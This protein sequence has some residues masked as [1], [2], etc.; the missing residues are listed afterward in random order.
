MDNSFPG[1]RFIA[2]KEFCELYNFHVE[3]VYVLL[4][5]GE[6][7][8]ARIGHSWRIDRQRFEAQLE[9]QIAGRGK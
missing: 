8:A 5:R 7:P 3:H 9:R 4:A 6:I 1:R 2:P